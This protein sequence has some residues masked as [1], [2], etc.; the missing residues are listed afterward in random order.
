MDF[1]PS[2]RTTA[3]LASITMFFSSLCLYY[4]YSEGVELDFKFV[5][6]SYACCGT[7]NGSINDFRYTY[8]GS[9]RNCDTTALQKTIAG[10]IYHYLAVIEGN[11]VCGT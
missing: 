8:Y 5:L 1:I 7:V 11:K 9:D 4:V 3:R 2:N 10:A 6:L